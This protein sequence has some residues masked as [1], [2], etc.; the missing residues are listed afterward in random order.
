[1]D[2][3]RQRQLAKTIQ[4]ALSENIQKELSN[5]LEGAMIT[6]S[7]VRVTPDLYIAR[8]Y[9]SIYNHANPTHVLAL[10]DKNNK[11]IRG[12]LGN[13][14]RN[15]VRS[16]PQLEFFKDDTLDEVQKLEQIFKEIKEKDAQIAK[17]RDGQQKA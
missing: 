3:I 4:V 7:G 10:L 8:V 17:D 11:Y 9:V 13:K 1:M 12:L 6:I 15:K 5:I 16:V 14:L 2:S